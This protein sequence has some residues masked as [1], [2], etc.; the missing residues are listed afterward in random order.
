VVEGVTMGLAY[1]LK[2]M[3]DLGIEPSELRLTGGG[4]KSRVWARIIADIFGYSTVTLRTSE[5]AAL[6]A[7]IHGAWTYCQVKG[8]PVALD[9]LVRDAVK[10]DK[11]SRMEPRKENRALYRELRTRHTELTRTLASA[12]YL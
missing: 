2:R 12:G 6:G 8:K 10:I 11:K 3:V 5:G 7:A 4:S 9:R 1:G